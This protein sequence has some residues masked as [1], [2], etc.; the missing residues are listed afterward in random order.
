MLFETHDACDGVIITSPEVF[1]PEG[2]A[3]TKE[4]FGETG[5]PAW[6]IGPLLYAASS[7]EAV[8]GEAALSEDSGEIMKFM[9][10]VLSLHG[11][12]SMLYVRCVPATF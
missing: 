2:I 11:E 3:A 9:N 4:W 5:R 10:S 1:E 12:R 8:A 7:N 6:A